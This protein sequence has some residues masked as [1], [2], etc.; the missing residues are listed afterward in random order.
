MQIKQLKILYL[1]LSVLFVCALIQWGSF[2]RRMQQEIEKRFLT[3]NIGS[4]TYEEINQLYASCKSN[5]GLIEIHLTDTKDL[6][7]EYPS[8]YRWII[9][10][11][12]DMF[13]QKPPLLNDLLSRSIYPPLVVS[14]LILLLVIVI[15]QLEQDYRPNQSI[16]TIM[17]LPHPRSHYLWTKLISPL[18]LMFLSWGMQYL[19]IILQELRYRTAF[20][21]ELIPSNQSPWT[22]DFYRI[23]FPLV[24]LIW[25]P[26]TIC[27][28]IM[29]PLIILTFVFIINGG[30]KSR[31][32]II[33]P[34]LGVVAI[35]LAINRIPNM[36]WILPVLLIGIYLN[37]MALLDKGQIA[38]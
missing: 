5:V 36:W 31:I 15:I 2:S 23:L 29:V 14:T 19:V 25:F 10:Q 26:A 32:Y 17:R 13:I 9:T 16:L 4:D 1:C 28:L 38:E 3:I 12:L 11:K 35:I 21:K 8:P 33:L 22:F 6:E 18:M 30:F 24:E 20:P 34:V 27:A 37:C 7:S